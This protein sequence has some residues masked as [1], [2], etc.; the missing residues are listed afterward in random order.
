MTDR[1]NS[2]ATDVAGTV[3]LAMREG[4]A[5]G[6]IYSSVVA[7]KVGIS[8]TDLE[9]LDFVATHEPVTA[10]ALAQ[11]T[12]MTTGAIT[13]VIDRLERAGFVKRTRPESDRRKVLI[14]T[15]AKFT[16]K[17]LPLY[18]PMQRRQSAVVGRC[19]TAQLK[20]VA[21]FMELTLQAARAAIAELDGAE[22]G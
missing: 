7:R 2:P 19:S 8:S 20:Q 3:M 15:T 1:S 22:S 6:I 16:K 17:V 10:G 14:S 21:A 18:E 12:G 9:C 4:S 5:L 11:E 13:G